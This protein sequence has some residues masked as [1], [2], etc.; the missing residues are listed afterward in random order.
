[1]DVGN[2]GLLYLV[3][4]RGQQV[5][6]VDLSRAVP[7]LEVIA[8]QAGEVG[9]NDEDVPAEEGLFDTLTG[10]AVGDDGTVY[11]ADGAT[12]LIR[13]VTTDGMLI[14]VAGLGD[15]GLPHTTQTDVPDRFD[16]PQRMV[17]LDGILYVADSGRHRI[18]AV[19]PETGEVWDHIGTADVA[20]YTGDGG[21]LSDALLDSPFGVARTPEGRLT[22]ADSGNHAI[23]SE[24]LSGRIETVVGRGPTGYAGDQD[25]AENASLSFPTDVA[26]APDGD[27][28]IA[29]TNNH[30]VRRVDEPNW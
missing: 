9:Y 16:S 29:D 27:L 18:A 6:A 24:L 30:V 20:G 4:S 12:N 7:T 14:N 13:A 23:R 15:D 2:N 3:E 10:V 21:A 25:A 17:F 1:M 28:V 5:L 22:V 19:D 26:Y 8:G 11:V